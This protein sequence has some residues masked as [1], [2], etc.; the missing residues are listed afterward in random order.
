[1]KSSRNTIGVVQEL[2]NPDQLINHNDSKVKSDNLSCSGTF[3][4]Y[5]MQ[6]EAHSMSIEVLEKRIKGSLRLVSL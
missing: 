1:M 4:S 3:R 2:Q 5:D 6:L